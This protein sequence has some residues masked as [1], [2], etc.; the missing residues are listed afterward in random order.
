MK[1]LLLLLYILIA[2]ASGVFAQAGLEID[3]FFGEK[4]A[5][6]SMVSMTRISGEQPFLRSKH[7]L[8]ISTFKGNADKFAQLISPCVIHDGRNAVGRNVRYSNGV[9]QYAFFELRGNRYIYYIDR[10]SAPK[11]SVILIYLESDKEMSSDKVLE[12]IKLL[13][14]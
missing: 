2:S 5:K 4:Y 6:D 1:R 12:L 9:L 7:L 11:P 10:S 13:S 8:S 3:Q 14:K